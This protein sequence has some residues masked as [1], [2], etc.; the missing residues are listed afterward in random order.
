MKPLL[1]VGAWSVAC[2]VTGPLGFAQGAG[3][4]G[5]FFPN[6][7]TSFADSVLVYDP[8]ANGGPA[9]DVAC[10]DPTRALGPPED[11]GSCDVV[12]SLGNGGVLELGF[13]DNV[14]SNSADATADLW[15]FEVGAVHE[16]VSVAVRPG[17]LASIVLAQDLGTDANG[18]G[19]FELGSTVGMAGIDIDAYF[20]G[21]VA[22]SIRFDA[23]QLTDDGDGS[24][25][26][27]FWGADID[28]VGVIATPQAQLARVG[29]RSAPGNADSYRATRPVLG[30]TLHATV[31]VADTTGHLSAALFGFDTPLDVALAGG[32]HLLCFDGGGGELLQLAPRFGP[33]ATFDIAVPNDP[34]LMGERYFTQALHY[35]GVVP[36]ALS[37][38]QDLYLGF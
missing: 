19:F 22:G 31:K 32:Q 7:A 15:I 1:V 30:G 12:V 26:P 2:L 23:V 35:G 17:D 11:V 38:A 13:H 10:Q 27:T 18:D 5:I 21:L 25:G 4:D 14:L 34:S 36:F 33:V 3:Y 37:N 29:N 20:P 8:L 6:G 9:P 28:A 24:S 16:V